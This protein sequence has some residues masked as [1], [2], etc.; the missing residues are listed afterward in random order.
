MSEA[1]K[2]AELKKKLAQLE[3]LETVA[4]PPVVVGKKRKA[5]SA[6]TAG[7]TASKKASKKEDFMKR[8][9]AEQLW[10]V[11]NKLNTLTGEFREFTAAQEE[12]RKKRSEA[13]S[14][15][16]ATRKANKEDDQ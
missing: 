2:I 8:T 10:G 11:Y 6:D 14:K 16:A 1:K 4:A 15:A 12:K 9:T 5:P 13:A 7:D 3:E